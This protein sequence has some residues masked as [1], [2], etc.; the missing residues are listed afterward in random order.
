MN[1]LWILLF[2][3]FLLPFQPDNLPNVL[4]IDDSIFIGYTPYV[5]G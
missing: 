2:G 1:T 3:I 4:I 5:L